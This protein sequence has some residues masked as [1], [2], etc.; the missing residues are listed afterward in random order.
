M[1][2]CEV[3]KVCSSTR[4]FESVTLRICASAGGTNPGSELLKLRLV[5]RK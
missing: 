3:M 4:D 1:Q 5:I 2:R